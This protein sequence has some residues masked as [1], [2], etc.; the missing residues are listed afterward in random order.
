MELRKKILA[1]LNNRDLLS[2]RQT[3]IAMR[4][5]ADVDEFRKRFL[6]DFR[7][8]IGS[9]VVVT[10]NNIR[11]LGRALRSTRATRSTLADTALRAKKLTLLLP[12]EG[13]LPTSSAGVVTHSLPSKRDMLLVLRA[14]PNLEVLTIKPRRD[15]DDKP[16]DWNVHNLLVE[17]REPESVVFPALA[18]LNA[19]PPFLQSLVLE[20]HGFD[21]KDLIKV[22]D[23]HRSSLRT[24]E[25]KDIKL[26]GNPEKSVSWN[27]VYS[28]L[29]TMDIKEL[30]MEVLTDP[31]RHVPNMFLSRSEDDSGSEQWS[32]IHPF[33]QYDDLENLRD[34]A[35]FTR[36]TATLQ[37]GSVVCGLKNLLHREDYMLY[38]DPE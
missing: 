25:L 17:S 38:H 26:T 30:T 3:C 14:M 19:S 22:L 20:N 5:A 36:H 1:E 11:L 31:M 28:T 9:G 4:D 27:N 23:A 21:G 33:H 29:V 13:D 8:D 6:I 15:E 18:S 7:S 37:G 34:Y 12:I 35:V 10:A 16:S 24:V 32:N 2:A